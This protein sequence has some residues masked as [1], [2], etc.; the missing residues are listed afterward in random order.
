VAPLAYDSKLNTVPDAKPDAPSLADAEPITSGPNIGDFEQQGG[1]AKRDTKTDKKGEF[2][3]IG[4]V[5]GN[6]TISYVPNINSTINRAA[7][8]VSTTNTTRA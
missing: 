6:Y 1:S 4:L 2:T 5:G 7:I 8:T 3:Q